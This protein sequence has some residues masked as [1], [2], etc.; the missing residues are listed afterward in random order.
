MRQ[1]SPNFNAHHSRYAYPEPAG[2]NPA[3]VS[4][5]SRRCRGWSPTVVDGTIMWTSGRARQR[6]T[7]I[8]VGSAASTA[9]CATAIGQWV[10]I[11]GGAYGGAGPYKVRSRAAIQ[12]RKR[13]W[14]TRATRVVSGVFLRIVRF[15]ASGGSVTFSLESGPVSDTAGNGT[16][17]EQVSIP[18]AK[19]WMSDADERVNAELDHLHQTLF[20]G[21]GCRSQRTVRLPR[22]KSKR[23][24]V[25]PSGS[26]SMWCPQRSDTF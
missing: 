10:A 3:S 26:F 13:F 15:N 23:A 11:G 12:L 2:I 17:I 6:A 24:P 7:S 20:L 18:A 19:S 14:V 16:V 21:L 1:L 4:S 22:A 8:M 5:T 9:C 25:S